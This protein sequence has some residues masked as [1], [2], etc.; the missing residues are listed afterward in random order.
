LYDFVKVL[1]Y[2][3]VHTGQIVDIT[4]GF[5]ILDNGKSFLYGG[6]VEI[7]K[8]SSLEKELL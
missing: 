6:M 4:D 7:S 5:I 1:S 8:L 3:A 2:G